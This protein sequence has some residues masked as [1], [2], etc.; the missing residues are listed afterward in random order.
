[1]NSKRSTH[2]RDS[3]G[4]AKEAGASNGRENMKCVSSVSGVS[5][6]CSSYTCSN[7]QAVFRG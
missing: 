5:S 6:W 7:M 4:V 2:R 3:R 1:M